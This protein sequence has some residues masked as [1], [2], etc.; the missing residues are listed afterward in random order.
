MPRPQRSL[1]KSQMLKKLALRKLALR[2]RALKKL[3]L[4][5]LAL[6]YLALRQTSS[7]FFPHGGP[8]FW[9]G[10]HSLIGHQRPGP[11][12]VETW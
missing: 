7:S 1:L 12:T 6:K 11:S 4:K 9:R 3:A 5:Y 10:H 8:A 2:K